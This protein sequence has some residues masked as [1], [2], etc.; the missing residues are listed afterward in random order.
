MLA[1]PPVRPVKLST[2]EFGPGPVM[3]L[4]LTYQAAQIAA[5]QGAH[6]HS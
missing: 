4:F 5:A 1:A 3:A 2:S 6:R